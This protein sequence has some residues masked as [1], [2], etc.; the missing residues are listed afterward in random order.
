MTTLPMEIVN[1]IIMMAI[2]INP[3]SILIHNYFRDVN[4]RIRLDQEY[5]EN[6]RYYNFIKQLYNY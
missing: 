4:E 6:L 2:T 1:K 5:L 3:T